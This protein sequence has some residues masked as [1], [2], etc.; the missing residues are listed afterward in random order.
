[1]GPRVLRAFVSR[2]C[3]FGALASVGLTG[4]FAHQEKTSE[5]IFNLQTRLLAI[6]RKLDEKGQ[7]ALDMGDAT[8]KRM[9]VAVNKMDQIDGDLARIKGEIDSLYEGVKTGQLP[10]QGADEP[11][12]AKSLGELA[13]R[14]S[15]VESAQAEMLKVLEEKKATAANKKNDLKD[16]A[17]VKAA[18]KSKKYKDITAEAPRL[19]G[20]EAKKKER[21]E[22]RYLYGESLY[23]LKK[24]QDAALVFDEILKKDTLAEL[25]PAIQLRMGDCLR[26]LGEKEAARVY[27]K[28]LVSQFPKTAEAKKAKEHMKKLEKDHG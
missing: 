10:N 17:S 15:A 28:E 20:G 6:E 23:H 16:L 7:A 12:L 25:K 19:F 3:L 13:D 2:N 1:M 18:F 4:C 11:S 27:Y 8:N 5:D 22:I 24:L 26:E 9:A 21:D 14:L